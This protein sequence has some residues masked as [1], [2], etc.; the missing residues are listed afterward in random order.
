MVNVRFSNYE[1]FLDFFRNAPRNIQ[2][3]LYKAYPDF[4]A[5]MTNDYMNATKKITQTVNKGTQSISGSTPKQIGMA[6]D[7]VK[8]AGK[9][10]EETA[11]A[12]SKSPNLVSQIG[13]KLGNIAKGGG[14]LVTR[15]GAPIQGAVN[16][17][18]PNSDTTDKLAGAGMIAAGIG[19]SAGVPF[20]APIAGGLVVG[21]LLKKQVAPAVGEKIGEK[22][23]GTGDGY[24]IYQNGDLIDYTNL[25]LSPEEQERINSYNKAIISQRQSDLDNAIAA[26]KEEQSEWDRIINNNPEAVKQFNNDYFGGSYPSNPSSDYGIYSQNSQNAQEGGLNNF[27]DNLYLE[28]YKPS[29]KPIVEPVNY[30]NEYLASQN[31]LINK[32]YQNANQGEQQQMSMN[33]PYDLGGLRPYAQIDSQQAPVPS[34]QGID[35]GALL[36]QFNEAM[37][38]D[39]RQN[40]VNALVNAF[41]ALGTPARKAPIY[42][43]GAN[44]DLRAIEQDQAGQV[45]PLPTNITNNYDKLMGQ[46]KIQQAQ[47][48]DILA[49]QKQAAADLKA[50]RE[51]I[52][53]Q[54]MMDALGRQFNVDSSMFA[55][56]DIAKAALQYVFNPNIQAQAN[57]QETIGKAPT[58]ATLKAAEQ[59]GE[60]AGKLD[61]IQLGKQYDAMIA[62]INNNAKMEEQAMIQSG[63]DRRTAAQ[64]ANQSAINQYTQLMNNLRTNAELNNALQLQGMRGQNAL[65]VAGIY[66]N[67]Q[68]GSDKSALTIG[69]QVYMEAVK[70][71][72]PVPQ[73]IKYAQV[74][75]P[76]FGATQAELNEL[77]R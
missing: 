4:A 62:N 45:Q 7:T 61:E 46:L 24:N 12:A 30:S 74:V 31:N 47:Q 6:K 14:R 60:I 70:S 19:A 52:A 39:Q 9:V 63:M 10:A 72:M 18:N 26:N 13:S 29:L 23:Y 41:G 2:N 73:A 3:I 28:Q 37:K 56:P 55:N 16:I 66:A 22:L 77:N 50:Q 64:L 8:G 59:R 35:Y 54:N 38:A 15:V 57:I 75:D 33:N 53:N 68:S 11:K 27:Q 76:N 36:N 21:D 51:Y 17:F 48:A 5:R 44:G 25:N 71:G 40:Q 42:Y 65:D 20:A 1:Q 32:L 43:V 34:Q 69:Q 58:Q 49:R 67:R